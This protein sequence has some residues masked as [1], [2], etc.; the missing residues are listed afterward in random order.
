[1][2]TWCRMPG[3]TEYPSPEKS[4]PKGCWVTPFVL[5]MTPNA[6]SQKNISPFHF[7]HFPF[8][9]LTAY[10]NMQYYNMQALTAA[11]YTLSRLLK[12]LESSFYS[13]RWLCVATGSF[14]WIRIGTSP[15]WNTVI[16]IS[17]LPLNSED[18]DLE[19]ITPPGPRLLN[20]SPGR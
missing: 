19:K 5:R 11:K 17:L 13:S 10:I 18:M 4:N 3:L 16:I 2:K 20:I 1:M 6:L 9:P 15:G 12:C 14:N 8:P 7:G